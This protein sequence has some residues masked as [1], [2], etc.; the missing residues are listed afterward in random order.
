MRSWRSFISFSQVRRVMVCGWPPRLTNMNSAPL[1]L[2]QSSWAR[3]HLPCDSR[4]TQSPWRSRASSA[5]RRARASSSLAASG[6]SAAAP[7]WNTGAGSVAAAA[8][9]V[10]A[11]GVPSSPA[12]SDAGGAARTVTGSVGAKARIAVSPGGSVT[13]ASAGSSA[14]AASSASTSGAPMVV[15]ASASA[16]SKPATVSSW[17]PSQ[18]CSAALGLGT[19]IGTGSVGGSSDESP[20]SSGVKPEA[21]ASIALRRRRSR[22]TGS[23]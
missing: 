17:R 18:G 1:S 19:S 10:P 9:S 6:C 3:R 14:S 23:W 2:V 21:S 8:G 7:G 15:S 12:P 4:S 13:E 5:R 22:S 20:V 11:A 16:S